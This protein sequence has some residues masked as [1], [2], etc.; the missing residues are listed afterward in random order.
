MR[1]AEA[2]IAGNTLGVQAARLAAMGT[3]TIAE[4]MRINNQFDD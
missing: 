3:T 1:A 2:Q 4:A